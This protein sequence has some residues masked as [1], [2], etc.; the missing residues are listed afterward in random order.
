MKLCI[1]PALVSVALSLLL[2]GCAS[3]TLKISRLNPGPARTEKNPAPMHKLEEKVTRPY[4]ILG[5]VS[6]IGNRPSANSGKA[7][8][9][10]AEEAA[11]MGAEALIGFYYDENHVAPSGGPDCWSQALAVKFL[12]EPAPA[13]R[14]SPGV[15]AIPHIF[16]G[17]NAG[18]PTKVERTAAIVR[19]FARLA[20]AQKGYYALLV[21]EHLPQ[22]FPNN[23]KSQSPTTR[24]AFGSSDAD[25]VVAIALGGV[26]S[27]NAWLV[28]GASTS[29]VAGIFS[30]SA[31]KVTWSGGA[32]SA[33]AGAGLFEGLSHALLPTG[34][35]IP[36]VWKGL[37][38]TFASLPEIST[39]TVK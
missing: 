39:A 4:E 12:A 15:V 9:I 21:D 20:L 29:L 25:A 37:Q 32:V 5:V 24:N 27:W 28:S 18:S 3:P 33:A 11:A 30:K 16:I 17:E 23:L 26:T 35:A 2:A 13:K 22:E 38:Q 31:N 36:A 6:A 7:R 14:P 1:N 8:R 34:R 10:M 19:K